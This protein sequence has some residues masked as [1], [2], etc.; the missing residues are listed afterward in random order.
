MTRRAV[1]DI[2]LI[3]EGTYP[4]VAGGVSTWTHDLVKSQKHLTF[5]LVLLLPSGMDLTSRYTIPDNVTGVTR[6]FVQ[7]LPEG[8]GRSR[9]TDRLLDQIQV[10][11]LSLQSQGGLADVKRILELLGPHQEKLG[12]RILLNSKSAWT[13]LRRMYDSSLRGSSFLDYFWSWRSSLAGL[14]SV[15]LSDLPRAGLYHAVSTGYAGLYA[16]RARLQTNRPVLLTEHGIYTN[17]RRIEIAMA[18]WLYETP[19]EDLN[20]EETRRDLKSLWVDTFTSYSRACYAACTKIITLYEGN[21]RLQVEDGADSAKLEIIPNGVD[22]DR[23]SQVQRDSPPRPPGVALIG[24]VVAIKDVKTFIRACAILRTRL[25]E[26][27]VWVLGPTGEEE[28]YFQE[29]LDL[30]G[31]LALEDTLTFTG[32]VRLEDYLGRIDV[33]ALTSISEAQPLVILE[34]GAAGIPTVAT[35]VGAC[36]EMILGRSSESP[37]LGPGGAVTPLSNPGATAQALVRLLMDRNW[38]QQ[39]A[40]AIQSRV[41]RYYN[42]LDLD[43]T[44]RELYESCRMQPV[45]AQTESDG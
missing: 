23:F 13:L 28:D 3:L 39:C 45:V 35:D 37:A 42:K 14:Y 43:R 44:Y 10:P 38:Y 29:C 33:I 21:Q 6:V 27:R 11:L 31:F 4:Y 24:R 34:A 19:S 18:D 12:R 30:V 1:A 36:R 9:W 32:K 5:H 25:P 15:L 40:G 26:V 20:A 41:R 8:V 16:A 2:C 7:E 22:Y 17:E